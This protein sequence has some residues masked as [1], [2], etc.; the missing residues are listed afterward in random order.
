MNNSSGRCSN[1]VTNNLKI[2]VH[3]KEKED[4]DGEVVS[5]MVIYHENA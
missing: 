4:K 3:W 5:K 1:H 2:K